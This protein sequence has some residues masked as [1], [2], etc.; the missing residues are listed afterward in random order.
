MT[1]DR[2]KLL[3]V[4][5]DQGLCKQLNWCFDEY[6]VLTAGDRPSAMAVLRRHTPAVVL[7]DGIE[8]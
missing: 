5:D 6:E 1:D 2:P 7:Q 8:N 3:I 4:E